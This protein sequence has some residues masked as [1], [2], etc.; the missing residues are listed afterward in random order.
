MIHHIGGD[1][2]IHVVRHGGP[3]KRSHRS[4]L[5]AF[6]AVTLPESI[7]RL[8]CDFATAESRCLRPLIEK[9]ESLLEI[10]GQRRIASRW[11]KRW[12]KGIQNHDKK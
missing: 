10:R 3:I 11:I 4:R 7:Y 9:R 1:V 5:V 6:G 2:S 12:I 8:V